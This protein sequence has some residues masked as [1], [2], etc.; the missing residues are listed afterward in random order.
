MFTSDTDLYAQITTALN[1]LILR[2]LSRAAIDQHA[3]SDG[4]GADRSDGSESLAL[5][6][7][8]REIRARFEDVATG[9]I[10]SDSSSGKGG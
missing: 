7:K 10:P 2:A 5:A 6:G 8:L 9:V 3:P 1:E 4:D